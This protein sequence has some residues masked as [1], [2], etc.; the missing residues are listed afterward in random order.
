MNSIWNVLVTSPMSQ[1]NFVPLSTLVSSLAWSAKGRVGT[2]Q[3]LSEDW[4]QCPH[5]HA[6]ILADPEWVHTHSY[7]PLNLRT[8]ISGLRYYRHTHIFPWCTKMDIQL[9]I[10]K[11]QKETRKISWVEKPN[12][13]IWSEMCKKGNQESE[14]IDPRSLQDQPPFITSQETLAF[15]FSFKF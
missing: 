5:L 11:V 7:I 9:P 4:C 1:L 14:N 8:K 2:M 6:R 12:G 13:Q 10:A 3:I 15:A